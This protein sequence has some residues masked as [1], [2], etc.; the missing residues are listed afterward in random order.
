MAVVFADHWQDDCL[1]CFEIANCRFF[2]LTHH[3]AV[4]GYVGRKNRSQPAANVLAS[5]IL[6]RH[7]A[8]S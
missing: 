7:Y 5:S 6:C 3:C 4:T 1:V 8:I 2:V